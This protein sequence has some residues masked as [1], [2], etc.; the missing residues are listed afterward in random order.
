MWFPLVIFTLALFGVAFFIL[1]YTLEQLEKEL[2]EAVN[3]A[4]D[5]SDSEGK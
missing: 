2:T 1:L 5:I 4:F 3:L